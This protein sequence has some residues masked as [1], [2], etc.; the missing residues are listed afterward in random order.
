[1]KNVLY[2]AFAVVIAV[3][4]YW[5]AAPGNKGE[6]PVIGVLQFTDNHLKTLDGF[7]SAM[8]G[9]GYVD[10]ESVRYVFEGSAPTQDQ[11]GPYMERLLEQR[12]DL[13]FASTT[14]AA[15]TAA[16]MCAP[17]GIPVIFAPV[18]DPVAAGIVKDIRRPEGNATGVRLAKSEGRRLQ[19]LAEVD[20][21][22][23]RVFVPFTPQD[24]SAA[25]SLAQ[26]EADAPKIGLSLVLLPF[27]KDM[28]VI[29]DRIVPEG[30]EAIFL[31]REGLVR[32]RI[33][34]FTAISIRRRLPLSTPSLDQVEMGALTGYGF[35]P[36]E[37][38][39]QAARLARQILEGAPIANLPVET[40]RDYCFLNM[41]SAR[42]MG[43][44]VPE[45]FLRRVNYIV[46]ETR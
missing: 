33:K 11:L 42:K 15:K 23:R 26:I 41:E 38:G 6:P 35:V 8:A 27:N 43:L 4:A 22:I 18:N 32:S 45:D 37:V 12:P 46:Y 36:E 13:V 14:P 40:A 24:P 44:H 16:R 39:K 21:G 29:G 17:L 19:S 20:P 31:P 25:A 9:Y 3:G 30:V 2:V 34:D 5:V 1:M 28:D 10:G 7:K